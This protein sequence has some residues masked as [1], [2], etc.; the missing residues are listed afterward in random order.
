MNKIT[1]ITKQEI[2]DLFE[3]GI[4]EDDV[5]N[6]GLEP[7]KYRYYG[8]LEI[9]TFLKRLYNLKSMEIYDLRQENAENEII[10]HIYNGD[11]EDNWIF[12]DERFELFDGS[13]EIFLDFICEIFHPEVR[14]EKSNWKLF[15]ETI[16][17]LIRNDGYEMFPYKKISGRNVYKWRVYIKEPDF[18]PFSKRNKM[19]IENKIIKISIPRTVRDEIYSTIKEYD[20]IVSLT[21]KT[22]FQYNEWISK[23]I[24]DKISNFYTPQHFVNNAYIV[25]TE[26]KSF[27]EST[28]PYCVF[29]AIEI[30]CR[31]VIE[32]EKFENKINTI[33][34]LNN[35]EVYLENKKIHIVQNQIVE[36]NEFMSSKEEGVKI[37]IDEAKEF[38]NNNQYSYA[39]EKI[40]DAFERIKTYYYPNLDKKESANRIIEELS[41]G[42]EDFKKMLHDEFLFL[43]SVGN[44]YRIRHHEKDRIE[45]CNQFQY[46]YFYNRCL[47]LVAVILAKL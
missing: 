3:N 9:V 37:L 21:S 7:I 43:T 12:S 34:N 38:Y 30:F 27:L 23:L 31:E 28:S 14:D 22:N 1:S 29:D 33:F 39:T 16:N 18:L 36:I 46:I 4:L 25:A 35:M 19:L 10:C 47:S 8:R 24:L 26:L 41:S 32:L 44:D 40:W 45:I 42:N 11:Y 5:W 15:F 17:N 2:F 20:E 13:D 6:I